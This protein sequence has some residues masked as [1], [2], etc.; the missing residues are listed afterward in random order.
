M[1]NLKK[2]LSLVLCL[3]MMLSI[4]VVGAGAAFGDQD[5]IEN[6]EAVDM[7]VALGII[8]GFEDGNYH[9]EKNITRAQAAKLIS[10]MVNGGKDAVKDVAT[11]SYTDVLTDSSSAWANKYVEFCSVEGIVAGVGG[12]R[13]APASNLTGTQLAKML[14]VALGYDAEDEGFLGASWALNVNTKAAKVGL[15]AGLE[16]V[17][18]SVAMSRDDAAQ[19][20]WNA[21]NVD[22][23]RGKTLLSKVFGAETDTGI[24]THIDYNQDTGVYTYYL[25]EMKDAHDKNGT[26]EPDPYR[27]YRTT[28]DYTD[29]FAQKVT[30]IAKGDK[31]LGV[32]SVYGD[33]AIVV[34][35]VW[36][37]VSASSI[38]NTHFNTV[39][40][41]GEKYFMDN[42]ANDWDDI[43]GVSNM[44]AY[45][46]YDN[47]YFTGLEFDGGD[48]YLVDE[49]GNAFEQYSFVGIDQDGGG[50]IDIFVVYP[51]VVLKTERVNADDFEVREIATRDASITVIPT[52]QDQQIVEDL[53]H[54]GINESYVN[55]RWSA[56]IQF[57]DIET[58]G[59]IEAYD[60][61]MAVPNYFTAKNIDIYT[62]LDVQSATLTKLS[63]GDKTITL[64]DTTYDSALVEWIAAFQQLSVGKTYQF[65]EVN[66]YLFIVDG[67]PLE[68]ELGDYA[69]VTKVANLREGVDKTYETNILCTDGKTYTV[70]VDFAKNVWAPGSNVK[71]TI[72]FLQNVKHPNTCRGC[73]ICNTCGQPEVGTLYTVYERDN[74]NYVLIAVPRGAN[75]QDSVFDVYQAYQDGA[76]LNNEVAVGPFSG[77]VYLNHGV[78][79]VYGEDDVDNYFYD[80]MRA[81]SGERGGDVVEAPEF[82]DPV[83]FTSPKL[84]IED[85]AVIFVYNQFT[86]S[87]SVVT[88]DQLQS[89]DPNTVNWA[90]TGATEKGPYDVNGVCVATVDLGYVMT[91]HDPAET[92]VYAV[93]DGDPVRT[94]IEDGKWVIS[95]DV[96][97]ANGETAT[98]TTEAS[99]I[100]NNFKFQRLYSS[101]TDG[102]IVE[103]IVDGST[104]VDVK[105]YE[106]NVVPGI[107]EIKTGTVTNPYQVSDTTL[108]I[109]G[110]AYKVSA[111]TIILNTDATTTLKTG[112]SVRYMCLSGNTLDLVEW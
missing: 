57:D 86:N 23:G 108:W 20:I 1:R 87:Y 52:E 95:V 78:M 8:D 39:K 104:L 82:V 69:V 21:L 36:G 41:S 80:V 11:S 90:F 40:I 91:N 94:Q 75:P 2:V 50:D 77:K 67:N 32:H 49:D 59:T 100:E 68:P 12:G 96:I 62:D 51:Y 112:D 29:L 79:G 24:L 34:S 101:L 111:D 60:Y 56:D 55:N 7:C 28:A 70:E 22:L 43:Y 46:D 89:Q 110:Q 98:Y 16:D 18:V 106:G 93:V 53:M 107:W 5:K 44:V 84:Y 35:D 25:G 66:G 9:P 13:F 48:Y 4:M 27:Y 65:V 71:E 14:L 83:V 97:L 88:G 99:V 30:V 10:V 73:D 102:Q 74:G 63:S 85:D 109:D 37:N 38:S 58:V 81:Q 3:A 105:N 61:V 72:E 103:L 33:A 26:H 54:N 31:A 45:N 92:T 42:V 76:T 15:Y 64:G 6:A 19:M 47:N 17:D